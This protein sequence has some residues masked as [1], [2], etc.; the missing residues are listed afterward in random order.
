VGRGG[1]G[2]GGREMRNMKKH[3]CLDL[4]NRKRSFLVFGDC[5]LKRPW[6]LEGISVPKEDLT[7]AL[8]PV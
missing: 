4:A 3:M 5:G 6:N 8:G 7:Q 2:E 1:R